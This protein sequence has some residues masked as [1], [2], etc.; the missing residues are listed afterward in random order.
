MR[1]NIESYYIYSTKEGDGEKG[2]LIL[3][4]CFIFS[5]KGE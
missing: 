4:S 2:A 3:G 1:E 5:T